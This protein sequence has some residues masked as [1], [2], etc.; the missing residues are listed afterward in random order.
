MDPELK[1][2]KCVIIDDE[3]EACDRLENL[4]NKIH[5]VQVLKKEIKPEI[6]IKEVI[7]SFPDIVFIDVE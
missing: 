2:I 1:N 5:G 3:Q 4:L 7:S 6:G